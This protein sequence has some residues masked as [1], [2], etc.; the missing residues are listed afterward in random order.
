MVVKLGRGDRLTLLAWSG[1]FSA[2]SVGSAGLAGLVWFVF[3]YYPL[4]WLAWLAWSELSCCIRLEVLGYRRLADVK[5]VHV[6]RI[7]LKP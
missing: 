1:L 5:S 4:G 3:L 6:C 2:F 7:D